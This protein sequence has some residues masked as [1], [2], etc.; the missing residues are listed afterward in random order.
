MSRS[1]QWRRCK[2]CT[3]F[4][5]YINPHSHYKCDKYGHYV[6]T[7]SRA[8]GFFEKKKKTEEIDD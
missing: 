5:K 1:F 2:Y 7:H 8:C 4:I 6:S 3:H